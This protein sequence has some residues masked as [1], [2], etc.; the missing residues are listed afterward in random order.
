MDEEYL[1]DQFNYIITY[2]KKTNQAIDTFLP[3]PWDPY[4]LSREPGHQVASLKHWGRFKQLCFINDAH[5]TNVGIFGCIGDPASGD[6]SG[7]W[8]TISLGEESL[9]FPLS[10][11]MDDTSLIGMALDLSATNKLLGS[12]QVNG[13]DPAIPPAP[14]IYI[15]TNDA[16]IVGFHIV[17]E[18]GVPYPAMANA[19]TAGA[20]LGGTEQGMDMAT[21]KT[22]SNGDSGSV[23]ET[24]KAATP[25]NTTTPGTPAF[26]FA[27]VPNAS[28]SGQTSAFGK[29]AFGFGAAASSAPKFGSSGFG[30]ASGECSVDSSRFLSLTDCICSWSVQRIREPVQYHGPQTWV[31]R[32]C[33]FHF[34]IWAEFI[35]CTD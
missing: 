18:D 13:D 9:T 27:A 16:V 7:V 24:S 10:S 21:E 5:A 28:T 3:L 32:V 1:P 20:S 14:I 35:R 6:E 29:S 34:D 11:D 8:S 2:D 19:S 23:M 25:M 30:S 17:N 22:G 33:V 15:Y 4:G 26:G 31:W 12:S